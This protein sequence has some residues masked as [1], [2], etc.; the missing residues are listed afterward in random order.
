M[1][2]HI[3]KLSTQI[4][5]SKTAALLETVLGTNHVDAQRDKRTVRA[6]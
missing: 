1:N 3:R 5:Q 2:L 4:K 6:E